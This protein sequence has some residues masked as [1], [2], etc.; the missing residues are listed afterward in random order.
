MRDVDINLEI[1]AVGE[2]ILAEATRLSV[3]RYPGT[4]G[5]HQTI[6]E[7]E[8][9]LVA[10]GL[11]T[12][13]QWFSYDLA[14]ANRTLR[15]VL[16][17]GALLA[18]AAGFVVLR[19]PLAGVLVLLGALLPGLVFLA[20]SPWLERLYRRDGPTR[21]ANVIGRRSVK[22]PTLTLIVMAHHDSKSQSLSFPYRMG[23]TLTAV[24]A[25]SVLVV[26]VVAGIITG[27]TPGPG[28][29]GPTAGC[30][31]GVA[32]LILSTMRSGDLSPGGV[33]NAGSTAILLEL[34]RTLPEM[35]RE[36]VELVFLSTGAEEDHMIGAMRWLEANEG[37]FGDR[38]VFCLN[39]DG[40]GAPGRTVLIE[41]FGF[42]RMFSQPMS[43][44]ARRAA[45]T[46]RIPVRGILMLP[47]IGIDAI[48]FAHHGIQCLT[49]S[50]GSL[51]PA[52]LSVHSA[53]D[54]PEHLDAATLG[55]I[56]ELAQ[57]LLVELSLETVKSPKSKV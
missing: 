41:R 44:A 5:D 36:R 25:A 34:A 39:F 3:P 52:T 56:A 47:G 29:L 31:A 30:A 7:V 9:R 51:G 55:R 50:S 13:L 37:V 22:D 38:P 46:L 6:A 49:L 32:A 33:D 42:G 26:L 21:T 10:A 17:I 45:I 27:Q 11:Q 18:G 12:E 15:T 19:S 43:A 23:L 1:V 8:K 16:V 24:A 48:P 28:W 14:P 54:H 40:A 4:P 53:N 20:W 2:R 35:I 57:Q